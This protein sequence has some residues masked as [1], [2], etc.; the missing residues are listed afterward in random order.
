[1]VDEAPYIVSWVALSYCWG[2]D[3]TKFTLT[4]DTFEDFKVGIALDKW[5]ATL[6][7]AIQV[8]QNLDLQY[9]WI[10]ALCILQDST[11]DWRTEAARMQDVYSGAA[12]TIIASES[13]STTAGIFS[14]RP[15]VILKPCE[16]PFRDGKDKY[17]IWL[18]PSYRNAVDMSSTS[19]LQTRIWTLQEGLLAPRSLS[20]R[21]DQLVWECSRGRFMESGH[22]MTM[23][24][25]FDSKDFLHNKSRK[26][27]AN[28]LYQSLHFGTLKQMYALEIQKARI[29]WFPKYI[30]S[31]G[32]RGS[33]SR[34]KDKSVNSCTVQYGKGSEF[35]PLL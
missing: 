20:F 25:L 33:T 18:R 13:P 5:P 29:G 12:F 28:S 9:I 8:T 34:L 4:S 14:S 1:M 7:D 35:E 24:H 26:N 15:P 17:T 22:V 3:V 31:S 30:T 16:L 27:K 23:D 21:K 6:R 10:D 32:V 19:P 11:S 2:P